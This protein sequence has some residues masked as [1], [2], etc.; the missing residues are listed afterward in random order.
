[1]NVLFPRNSIKLYGSTGVSSRTG[2]DYD[3]LG[4]AWQYR[5]GRGFPE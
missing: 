3:G 1:M 5:W 4:I 2:D